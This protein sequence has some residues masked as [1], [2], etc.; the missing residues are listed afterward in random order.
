MDCSRSSAGSR[1]NLTQ[2]QMRFRISTST[3]MYNTTLYLASDAG[4]Y[5]KKLKKERKRRRDRTKTETSIDVEHLAF[6]RLCV[7]RSLGK[8]SQNHHAFV[9]MQSMSSRY[10]QIQSGAVWEDLRCFYGGRPTLSFFISI[11]RSLPL[12]PL[13]LHPP[14]VCPQFSQVSR[15]STSHSALLL[16][17][18]GNQTERLNV[19]KMLLGHDCELVFNLL[20]HF[21][22]VVFFLLYIMCITLYFTNACKLMCSNFLLCICVIS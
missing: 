18:L 11:L 17:F 7:W 2:C 20:M 3:L 9:E 21:N 22:F 12:R 1:R 5:K 10:R 19:S 4:N 6:G 13:I 14:S 16:A 15:F 8:M